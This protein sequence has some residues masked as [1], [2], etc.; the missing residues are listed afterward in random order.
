MSIRYSERL[1]ANMFFVFAPQ[2]NQLLAQVTGAFD[3]LE[4]NIIEARLQLSSNGFALY[5]F[6][7]VV[8]SPESA[9]KDDYM[10]FLEREMRNLILENDGNKSVTRRNASRALKHFPIEPR[11][12]FTFNQPNYTTMEVVAQDQ[13]G[14]LHKVAKI[15]AEHNLMLSSARIATFGERVEDIFYVQHHN[16][17]QVTEESVLNS[18]REQ[19]HDALNSQTQKSKT[20]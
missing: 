12:D 16:H 11:I 13:P 10:Q 20:L 6:N 3:I 15:L 8:P 19:I 7:A 4:L 1:E 9:K 18:L 2:T 17:S 14:L 5:S